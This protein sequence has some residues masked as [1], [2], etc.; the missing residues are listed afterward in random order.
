MSPLLIALRRGSG[1][2]AIPAMILLGFFAGTRGGWSPDWG[3]TSGQLQQHGVLLVPLTAALAAW[4]SSRDRRTASTS[5]IRTYPR[6]PLPWLVLNSVGAI[7]AGLAGWATTFTVMA[8]D[9]QGQS[10]PYWSVVLLGPL[11]VI[12][13]AFIGSAAGHHLPRYLA[14]PIVAAVVWVVLAYGSS[15]D[16]PLLARLSAVD[17]QC[18]EVSA[19][20]VLST[21]AGQWLWVTALAVI[22]LAALA[23]PRVVHSV[24]LAVVALVVGVAGV[25][26]IHSSDGQLTEARESTAESCG[27]RNGVTVCM[28]PE[29]AAGVDAWL[30]AISRYRDVFD[31]LGTRPDLY[32]EHGLRPGADAERIG[33]IRPGITETDVVMSLAQRLVPQP[34][35]CA[36]RVDGSVP[37][38]AAE[39]NALL[40]GWLTHRV[41]PD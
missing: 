25:S 27:T 11:C 24:S 4:D 14:A 29:H 1:P 33:M 21:V 23:L 3:W 6:S 34:P 10:S 28:W 35:A 26:L 17:R 8:S 31:D 41:R 9:V 39:A 37:Y 20:P 36:I 13:A 18:C 30:G 5:L 15:S 38:P 32:L 22:A 7:L 12:T 19:Q 16:N 2:V 40:S